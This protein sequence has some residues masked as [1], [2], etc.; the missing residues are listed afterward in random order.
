MA[1]TLEHFPAGKRQEL[2]FVVDLIREGFVFATERRTVP[3]LGHA[4]L[5]KLILFGSDDAHRP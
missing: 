1:T 4:K 2:A 5:L 3:R